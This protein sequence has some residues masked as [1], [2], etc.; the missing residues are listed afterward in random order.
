MHEAKSIQKVIHAL[1]VHLSELEQI[2]NL[3]EIEHMQYDSIGLFGHKMPFQFADECI[4][5]NEDRECETN[6]LQS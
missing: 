2:H 4:N 6:V 3:Y 5:N 1:S